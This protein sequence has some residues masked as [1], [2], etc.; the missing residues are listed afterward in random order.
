MLWMAERINVHASSVLEKAWM[1][2][3]EEIGALQAT[4]TIWVNRRNGMRGRG[5]ASDE[6][7]NHENRHISK[8]NGMESRKALPIG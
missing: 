5:N 8:G 4:R 2:R 6:T 1:R 7:K 3:V